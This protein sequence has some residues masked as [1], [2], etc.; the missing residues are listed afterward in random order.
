MPRARSVTCQS[1]Q[2]HYVS[3]VLSARSGELRH[4]DALALGAAGGA[5]SKP[6]PEGV[7]FIAS[8]AWSGT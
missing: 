5:A 6:L 2:P 1:V 3:H 7:S 8:P 4:E